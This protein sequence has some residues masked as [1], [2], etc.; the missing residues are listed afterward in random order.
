MSTIIGRMRKSIF[1]LTLTSNSC[2]CSGVMLRIISGGS[3][4]LTFGA[5]P[6]SAALVISTCSPA[7]GGAGPTLSS[8]SA[9]AK[10]FFSPL[11]F[12]N[13][14]VGLVDS[15]TIGLIPARRAALSQFPPGKG[16]ACHFITQATLGVSHSFSPA[17]S[18]DR[19][20]RANCP[21][22]DPFP[23]LFFCTDW[24]RLGM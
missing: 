7:V 17:F 19:T 11:P 9:M 1:R 21:A 8:A 6:S 24:G 5:P 20:L 12:S 18:P 13:I 23:M 22:A 4:L 10:L 3:R 15:R 16:I 2:R 14:R